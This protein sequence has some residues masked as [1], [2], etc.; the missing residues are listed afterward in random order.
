MLNQNT[1]NVNMVRHAV[2]NR[3]AS[4]KIVIS[5]LKREKNVRTSLRQTKLQQTSAFKCAMP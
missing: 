4:K 3:I 2:Q 1:E 5:D